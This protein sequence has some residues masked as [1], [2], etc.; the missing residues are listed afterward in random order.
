M[1]QQILGKIE[2][3]A[4]EPPGAGLRVRRGHAVKSANCFVPRV[5]FPRV[6]NYFEEPP[7]RRPELLG[8]HH[9]PPIERSVVAWPGIGHITQKRRHVCLRYAFFGRSPDRL[10]HAATQSGRK[11]PRRTRR[12]RRTATSPGEQPSW[13]RPQ[14][15]RMCQPEEKRAADRSFV[16]ARCPS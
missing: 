3:R 13:L 7:D 10:I 11:R 12:T 4:E 6:G 15:P 5:T 16:R 1:A 14:S 9:R 2:P 8:V